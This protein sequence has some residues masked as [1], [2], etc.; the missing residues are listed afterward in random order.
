MIRR[1]ISSPELGGRKM[2]DEERRLLLHV[3]RWVIEKE[4]ADAEKQSTTSNWADEMEKLVEQI[5]PKSPPR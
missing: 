1:R 2:T 5:R 3:A 4:N